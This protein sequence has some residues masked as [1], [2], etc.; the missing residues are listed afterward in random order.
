MQKTK[1]R[2]VW[3][4]NC[5]INTAGVIVGASILVVVWIIVCLAVGVPISVFHYFRGNTP[6]PARWLYLLSDLIS[7]AALGA[8]V[9]SVLCDRRYAF[10]AQ[11]YR[12]AFYFALAIVLGY[13]FHAFFFGIGFFLVA[14]V[15]TAMELFGLVIAMMN[16]YHVNK[17]CA[18]LTLVGCAWACYRMLLAFF[19]FFVV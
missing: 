16:F 6:L 1:R 17:L 2:C 14:F 12:G 7:H 13:L 18:L 19:C 11:K 5:R 4:R 8:A 10:E 15:L 3:F 9:G